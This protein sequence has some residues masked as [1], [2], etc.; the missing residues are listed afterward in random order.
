V[1][2]LSP[3]AER[4]QQGMFDEWI[5]MW[6]RDEKSAMIMYDAI[7]NWEGEFDLMEGSLNIPLDPVFNGEKSAAAYIDEIYP[8]IQ[9]QIDDLFK[10]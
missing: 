5:P 6:V 8:Q 9:S 2:Y 1:K 3:T 10:Q 4:L 7:E